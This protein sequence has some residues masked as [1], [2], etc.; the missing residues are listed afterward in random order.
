M[1]VPS[2]AF[3]KVFWDVSNVTTC[4]VTGDNLLHDTWTILGT[5]ANGWTSTAGAA[6]KTS[7]AITARTTF[8]LSCIG[9]DSSVI[10][11]TAVVNILPIFEEQ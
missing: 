10:D 8:T 7:S 2:G 3:T 1:L 6:G 11:D 9:L 4:T 5:L